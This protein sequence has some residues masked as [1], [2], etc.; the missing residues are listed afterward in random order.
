MDKIQQEIDSMRQY[1]DAMKKSDM[2]G[3]CDNLLMHLN[4]IQ[5]QV[6]IIIYEPAVSGSAWGLP[7]GV[8]QVGVD[9]AAP[10]SKSHSCRVWMKKGIS[11]EMIIVAEEHYR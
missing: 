7:N 8:Y 2:Y 4:N 9:K 11:G 10:N 5:E 6:K 3:D 1:I